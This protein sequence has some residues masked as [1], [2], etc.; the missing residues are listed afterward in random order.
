MRGQGIDVVLA[1]EYFDRRKVQSVADRGNAV[2]VIV[3]VQPGGD[4]EAPDYFSLV[5]RWVQ[6]LAVAFSGRGT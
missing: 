4:P 3:P 1:A 2:A 5:D 6:D